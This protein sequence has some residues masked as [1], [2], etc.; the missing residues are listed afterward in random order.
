MLR[1]QKIINRNFKQARQLIL[2]IVLP[3][4]FL[5]P[6]VLFAQIEITEVM[7]DLEGSDSGREWIEIYN[8]TTEDI[9]LSTWRLFEAETNHKIK[10]AVEGGP[11]SLPA[12]TYGLLVD[13]FEK[14]NLDYP[15]FSG[16]VF[17]SA[18]SLSNTSETLILRNNE[19]VDIDS[20]NYLAEWGAK[21]DGNSLQKNGSN[22]LPALPTPG[23][24]NGDV[25]EAINLQDDPA[26]EPQ[27]EIQPQVTTPLPVRTFKIEPQVF[28]AITTPLDKPI[29]GAGFFFEGDAWGLKEKPLVNEEYHW[30]FGDGGSAKGQ[31]VL[32]VYQHPGD[33]IIVL[34]VISGEYTG[35][36]RF[37]VEV[38][39]SEIIIYNVDVENQF[40]EIHNPS[41]HELNLSWWRLRV[42]GNY[43]ALPKNTIVLPK[44]YL[45][46]SS[47]ITG[48]TLKQNSQVDLLYPNGAVAY[49]YISQP[50]VVVSV[51]QEKP[52]A[53]VFVNQVASI[54]K[55]FEPVAPVATVVQLEDKQEPEDKFESVVLE[56]T[57]TTPSQE[58]PIESS[59]NIFNKWNLSLVGIVSVASAGL[60]FA[61][62]QDS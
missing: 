38:L 28:A 29:A 21:G 19:L 27:D 53:I 61:N 34:Q 25:D 1:S 14:F 30:T 60:I 57:T 44:K 31:K 46:F 9:D 59:N 56:A 17:D 20:M 6:L 50:K 58:S 33:Y 37:Q 3:V 62:K 39:P 2:A 49:S 13:N 23:V 8:T 5:S 26:D 54:Q 32:Y 41:I 16:F 22:W 24:S 40:I 15:S 47:V 48:L 45:K 11:T 43:F 51:P 52:K 10:S 35:A 12:N 36:D 42:D 4:L 18:F 7:Y 55:A